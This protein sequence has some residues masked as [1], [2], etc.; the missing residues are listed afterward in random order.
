AFHGQGWDGTVGVGLL[1]V[2]GVVAITALGSRAARR[3]ARREAA[4]A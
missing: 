1:A 2:A 4:V 3:T